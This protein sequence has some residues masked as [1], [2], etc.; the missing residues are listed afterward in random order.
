MVLTF[1]ISETASPELAPNYGP[2]AFLA[3]IQAVDPKQE[4]GTGQYTD[5]F[6]GFKGT[7]FYTTRIPKQSAD[8]A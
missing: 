4:R 1:D 6:M 2:L 7:P 5:A 3:F 8:E